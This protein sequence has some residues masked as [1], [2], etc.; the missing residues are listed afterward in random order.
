MI[1]GK[2]ERKKITAWFVLS[3]GLKIVYDCDAKYWP[4][5]C[6][7]ATTLLGQARCQVAASH[8]NVVEGSGMGWR[9]KD[10]VLHSTPLVHCRM[11]Q[12]TIRFSLHT[13]LPQQRANVHSTESR[14]KTEKHSDRRVVGKWQKDKIKF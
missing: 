7:Q 13:F 10:S 1:K 14:S 2:L 4:G 12:P 6:S 3:N 5:M 9:K 11:Y 8:R